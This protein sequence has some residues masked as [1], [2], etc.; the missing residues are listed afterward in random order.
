MERTTLAVLSELLCF[1]AYM[2]HVEINCSPLSMSGRPVSFFTTSELL[3]S[4][5]RSGGEQLHNITFYC[6]H[7]R[8]LDRRRRRL[9]LG[10]PSEQLGE[11]TQPPSSVRPSAS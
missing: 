9:F 7:H 5:A 3:N 10:L 4:P 11:R 8:R 1:G 6:C 2:H